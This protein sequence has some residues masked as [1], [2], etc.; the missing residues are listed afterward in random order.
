MAAETQRIARLTPLAE[1]LARI[2]AL[3]APVAPR[4]VETQAALGRVLAEDVVAASAMPATARALRDGYAVRSDVVLDA[5]SYAPVPLSSPQP[6]DAGDA[7]PKDAD[8]VAPLDAVAIRDGQVAAIAPVAPGDGVLEAGADIAV[9]TVLRQAGEALRASDIAVLT[10]AKIG[11]VSL[12]APQV[13]VVPARLGHAMI[14]G[15]V[16]VLNAAVVAAGA[17]LAPAARDLK[18]ALADTNAD[19]VIAVGGTGVGR[20]DA[21]V[22][23]LAAGGRVEV[24]GVA[25]SPGETAAFG[26]AGP[27][28]VLLIPGR[29]DAALAAWLT[30]G[31]RLVA[32]LSGAAESASAIPAVLTR[33]HASPLGLTEV[34][35]VRVSGGKAEPI[36]SGY[37]P[38]GALT[39]ADGWI[40][41]PAESEGYPAGAPVMV[42]PW[43]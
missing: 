13:V 33:K 23:T 6:V 27:R 25:L 28:P 42:R 16:R 20:N 29:I 5:S 7:L 32:R 30:L 1:V 8:A 9:G 2:D 17:S 15:A 3:V 43:P 19:V 35:P 39:Q 38:L 14:D 31:E 18:T 37:W 11:D 40:L 12:R 21:S 34:V 41:V 22:R 26:L 4:R 24:H 10:A 36:A